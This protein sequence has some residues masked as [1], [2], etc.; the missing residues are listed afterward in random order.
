MI[1]KGEL[2]LAPVQQQDL[3]FDAE[4]VVH[5]SGAGVSGCTDDFLMQL[6]QELAQESCSAKIFGHWWFFWRSKWWVS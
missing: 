3:R 4:E 6:E 5:R 1:A 2:V